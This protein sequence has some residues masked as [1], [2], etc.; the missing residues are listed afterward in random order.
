MYLLISDLY[1]KLA[2]FG[3]LA[4]GVTCGGLVRFRVVGSGMVTVLGEVLGACLAFFS[5]AC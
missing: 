1:D 2:F 4:A 3:V 5:L